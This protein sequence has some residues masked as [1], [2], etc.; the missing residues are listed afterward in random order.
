M[1]N[2]NEILDSFEF[3]KKLSVVTSKKF[4]DIFNKYVINSLKATKSRNI[5]YDCHNDED[6][7]EV[8][9]SRAIKKIVSPSAYDRLFNSMEFSNPK[10]KD[11]NCIIQQIQIC[12][13]DYLHFFVCFNKKINYYVISSTDLI[14]DK[15]I[16]YCSSQHHY[17][18]KN[19]EGQFHITNKNYKFFKKYLKKSIS[20][21]S[22]ENFIRRN[23]DN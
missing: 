16:N 5:H 8:K 22:L 13:F 9:S 7:I 2:T 12:N 14:D 3:K 19:K 11:Y 10:D 20:Y 21:K 18:D 23:Y 1:Y 17:S 15:E 4:G 6:R